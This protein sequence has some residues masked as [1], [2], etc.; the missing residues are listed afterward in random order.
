MQL[1]IIII[2]GF[3][4]IRGSSVIYV[5]WWVLRMD[6]WKDEYWQNGSDVMWNPIAWKCTYNS[7]QIVM[8]LSHSSTH[9]V[10]LYTQSHRLQGSITSSQV[11]Q[12][13]SQRLQD[14][15]PHPPLVRC[16]CLWRDSH[17]R[18]HSISRTMSQCR[19]PGTEIGGCPS[20]WWA[21]TRTSC[22][23]SNRI[24][25]AFL[26]WIRYNFEMRTFKC[27]SLW[28][29]EHVATH[30]TLYTQFPGFR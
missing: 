22:V 23:R 11:G 20:P 24:S 12:S 14:I 29:L 9:K 3:R 10:F 1:W 18:C 5:K 8:I 7:I 2:S 6:K 16:V 26:S 13:Y 30:M 27:T 21:S 4:L 15:N 17:R 28:S 19:S 25:L